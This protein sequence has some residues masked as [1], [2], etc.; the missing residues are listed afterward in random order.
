MV[1]VLCYNE[2]IG[3]LCLLR[4]AVFLVDTAQ[5]RREMLRCARK[6]TASREA[7]AKILIVRADDADFRSTRLTCAASRPALLG[8]YSR[9]VVLYP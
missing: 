9:R 5:R 8:L 6:S 1:T 7:L 2:P 3:P 4:R